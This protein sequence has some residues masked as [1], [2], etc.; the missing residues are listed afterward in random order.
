MVLVLAQMLSIAV[1]GYLWQFMAP[2]VSNDTLDADIS[3]TVISLLV[4]YFMLPALILRILWLAPLQQ[5]SLYIALMAA[6]GVLASMGLSIIISRFCL[7]SRASVGALILA[8]SFPNATYMGL[9]ILQATFGDWSKN[10]AL[11]F[12]MFACT[13]ILL[14]LGIFISSS[15]GQ[16]ENLGKLLR[17][18]LKVPAIWATILA[19][20]LN[21]N[22]VPMPEY[23][24]GILE[25]MGG[26]VV[27]LMLLT[28]GL[29]LRPRLIAL[30]DIKPVLIISSIQLLFMPLMVWTTG[31]A[32]PISAGHLIPVII[33]GAMPSMLLGLVLCNRYKLDAGLY[34]SAVLS[35]SLLSLITLPMILEILT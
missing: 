33:V 15:Y 14:S 24:S 21:L 3:R 11:Q 13:P 30:D 6:S 28:L 32:L 2:K 10:F 20:V 34:A 29:S 9:P 4:Y 31:Q 22:H 27:P 1:F 8:A 19:V 17:S 26:T 12:D 25:K 35:S 18:M 23:L 7:L 16:Q 5:N